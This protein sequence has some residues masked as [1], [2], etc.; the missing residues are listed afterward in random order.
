MIAYR[1]KQK[2]ALEKERKISDNATSKI[3]IYT[4]ELNLNL[5]TI[6]VPPDNL[7]CG[8]VMKALDGIS[9]FIKENDEEAKTLVY[10]DYNL[11]CL[12]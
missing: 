2:V 12:T 8:F 3:V 9:E 1:N 6:Y 4:P 10:G 11:N 7:D 5:I